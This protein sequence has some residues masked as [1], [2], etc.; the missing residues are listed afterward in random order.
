[1][2]N[3]APCPLH[4]T[5]GAPGITELSARVKSTKALKQ[6]LSRDGASYEFVFLPDKNTFAINK[7]LDYQI[8]LDSPH[9]SIRKSITKSRGRTVGGIIRVRK[10]KITT[11]EFSGHYGENWTDEIRDNFVEFMRKY[12]FEVEHSPW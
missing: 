5:G 10:G 9:V 7:K 2:H 3:G 8:E 6:Q 1:M 12:G 11:D 4:G